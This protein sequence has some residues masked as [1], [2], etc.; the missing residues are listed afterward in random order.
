MYSIDKGDT[1]RNL[2][3]I[4][5]AHIRESSG[6][7]TDREE[8]RKQAVEKRA[9]DWTCEGLIHIRVVG[10][11]CIEPHY[12]LCINATISTPSSTLEVIRSTRNA[13]TLIK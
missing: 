9:M 7:K 8:G 4:S 12:L 10:I 6:N 2:F 13:A 11:H 3:Y 1:P 5:S